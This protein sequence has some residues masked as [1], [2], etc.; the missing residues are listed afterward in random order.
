MEQY[1]I[2]HGNGYSSYG[3][4]IGLFPMS[5]DRG[6]PLTVS[7]MSPS[8]LYRYPSRLSYSSYHDTYYPSVCSP[9]ELTHPSHSIYLL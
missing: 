9:Y 7:G 5:S 3:G 1:Y 4:S 2:G 8:H 6:V